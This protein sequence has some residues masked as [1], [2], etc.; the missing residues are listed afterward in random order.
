M[1]AE[2]KRRLQKTEKWQTAMDKAFKDVP[3]EVIRAGEVYFEN[4]KKRSNA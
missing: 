1:A 3:P 4:R 2:V